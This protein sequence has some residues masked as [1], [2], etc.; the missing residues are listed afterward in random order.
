M[1][2]LP[3]ILSVF[4]ATAASANVHFQ[5]VGRP[6]AIRIDGDAEPVVSEKTS[7][8]NGK[9]S[10]TFHVPLDSITTGIAMRDRHTKEKYLETA[11][12]PT[13]DYVVKDC[14][15]NV[16]ESTCDGSLTLHGVT[17]SIQL[18][19]AV[20]EGAP[21]QLKVSTDFSLK[22][23][24]YGIAIPTFANITVADEVKVHVDSET[25]KP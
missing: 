13:A 6:S 18:K 1:K 14:A 23:S 15:L 24:D 20:T 8:K 5:A 12:Y 10:G 3:L 25:A 9:F 2:S 7:W 4:A 19:F 22:L 11:K 16:G 17:K 21:K